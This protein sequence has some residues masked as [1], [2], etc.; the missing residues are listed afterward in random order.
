M[1]MLLRFW[2]MLLQIRRQAI[3]PAGF[4]EPL[5]RTYCVLP[6][7][8]GWRD[9]LP[10]YRFLSFI[11]LN[12]TQWL[13][14]QTQVKKSAWIMATQEVIYLKPML[15]FTRFSI[16]SEVIGWD[17]KYLFFRHEFKAKGKLTAISLCK[18]MILSAQK[19]VTP[20]QIT[21]SPEQ[22]NAQ[23]SSLQSHQD[24]VKSATLS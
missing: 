23:I 3:K 14:T 5:T 15:P 8:L 16:T 24:E 7:D 12:T 4:C 2:Y 22:L 21:A 9:H 10:N 17:S 6:H 18:V 13:K 20:E 1:N 11:E 19:S